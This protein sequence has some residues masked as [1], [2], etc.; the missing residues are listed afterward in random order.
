MKIKNS[1]IEIRSNISPAD[2]LKIIILSFLVL[3]LFA[4]TI[5]ELTGVWYNNDDYSHGFFVIPIAFFMLWQKRE[6]LFLVASQ[7][8]WIGFPFF[9]AGAIVYVISFITNFHTLTNISMII[10]ILSL[11][12]FISGWKLTVL[13]LFPVLFLLF[14]FPI[15]SAYYIM[16]T[17]P[18]KLMITTISAD[19][20][21]LFGITV[22]QDGNL[23]FFSNTQLEVA[24][25]CSGIR[26]LYSYIMLGCVFALI[27]GKLILKVIM[28][29]SAIPLSLFVNIVRVTVTGILS[30]Y[31]GPTVAQGFF[32]E[33]TGFFL[34][35]IG[36]IILLL[37]YYLVERNA[38]KQK[39]NS[40]D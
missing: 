30:N 33:F 16:I 40:S 5:I 22:Y 23:L 28:V 29:L 24:E 4:P 31:Y 7:S 13:L 21:E 20:I 38:I 1:I 2:Q 39:S 6:K 17:N 10:L 12:I 35:V 27:S 9:V 36:F 18:L 25:A 8:S 26:S 37:V 19:I 11:L 34:F 3:I 14:M 15:P 32:H